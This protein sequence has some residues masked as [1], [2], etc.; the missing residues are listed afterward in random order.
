L[1]LFH[2]FLWGV[3]VGGKHVGLGSRSVVFDQGGK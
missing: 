2:V 1:F 3:V